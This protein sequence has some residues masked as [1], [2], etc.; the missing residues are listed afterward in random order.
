MDYSK[1]A[2]DL[3]LWLQETA[4]GAGMQGYALG[5]SGG[6]DSAVS[7]ALAVRAVGPEHVWAAWLPC[8]SLEEDAT[9]A[10]MV[11]EALH[12]EPATVDLGPAFDALMA[13]LPAGT[14]M[15]R[16]NIKPRLRMTTLYYLAQSNRALVLGTGNKPEITVGYFT[17]YGDG[18]V[19]LEPLGELYKRDVRALARILEIPEPVITR[20][21]TAGLWPGQTDEGE[22]GITYDLLDTILEAWEAGVDPDAPPE[23]IVRVR[24][25]FIASAHKRAMPPVFAVQRH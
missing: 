24:Q 6:I 11:S 22:L 17:K 9:Y 20:A 1:L 18:G 12:L 14:D 5:L 3:V 2:D 25:M 19:D 15:A 13:A 8:H 21:P 4:R 7:A 23:A 10:R 16:A